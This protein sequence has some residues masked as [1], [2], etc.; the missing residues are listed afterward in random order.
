[1]E[2]ILFS[3]WLNFSFAFFMFIKIIYI[4]L[5]NISREKSIN[6]EHF[7]F[8]VAGFEIF[9]TEF[10]CKSRI[11]YVIYCKMKK[12]FWRSAKYIEKY[13]KSWR[14]VYSAPVWY[15]LSHRILWITKQYNK[16]LMS[17][18]SIFFYFLL[19]MSIIFLSM[20][21]YLNIYYENYDTMLILTT[22]F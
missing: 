11:T 15:N 20:Y 10:H 1:M 6:F 17:A 7:Q 13:T 19:L 12:L 21:H 2:S 8:T 22:V 9:R 16:K 5:V 14:Y 4:L 3:V 18:I